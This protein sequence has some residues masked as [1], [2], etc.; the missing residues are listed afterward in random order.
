M[1]II[2]SEIALKSC[3]LKFN[4]LLFMQLSQIPQSV[5]SSSPK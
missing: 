4:A 3:E 1:E 2:L 5:V